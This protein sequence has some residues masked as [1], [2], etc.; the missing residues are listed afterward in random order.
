MVR[1]G[2]LVD[3]PAVYSY[4]QWLLTAA[5]FHNHGCRLAI[6]QDRGRVRAA[7]HFIVTWRTGKKP[8]VRND[9]LDGIFPCRVDFV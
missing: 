8:T 1:V 7:S 6:L 3:H 2:Y 5:N 4:T 9:K